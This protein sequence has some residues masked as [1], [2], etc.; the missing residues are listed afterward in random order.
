MKLDIQI[1]LKRLKD[2]FESDKQARR[3]MFGNSIIDMGLFYKMVADKATIN[4]K[5][6]GDPMLSGDEM[7]KIVT[8]LALKE[9]SEEIEVVNYIKKQEEIRKTFTHFKG[10]FPPICLN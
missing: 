7:L 10:G 2:F 6:N 8:D 9:V 5:N 4:A 3:D 1:Y